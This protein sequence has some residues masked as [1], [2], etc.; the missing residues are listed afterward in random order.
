MSFLLLEKS[1]LVLRNCYT[2]S[3]CGSRGTLRLPTCQ[4]K[5]D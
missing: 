1:L 3:A 4:T 2:N 5:E